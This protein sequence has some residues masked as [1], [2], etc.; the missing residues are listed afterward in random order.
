MSE[1]TNPETVETELV[2]VEEAQAEFQEEVNMDELEKEFNSFVSDMDKATNALSSEINMDELDDISTSVSEAREYLAG[3]A[4]G[5]KRTAKEKAYNTLTSLPL[6]GGWAKSQ[7]QEAQRDALENSSVKDVLDGIFS[8]FEAKK[9]RLLDLTDMIEQMRKNLVS[10]EAKLGGYITKLDIIIQ[11]PN[12][13]GRDKRRAVE[14]SVMAQAQDKITKEM[15]YNNIDIITDLMDVLY[16]K[17]IKALP[18]LKNTLNNSLNIVGTIN[19]IKDAVDM[20]NTL[21]GLTNEINQKSTATVQELIVDVTKSL[22]EGTDIEFYKD[23]AKRN[24]QFNQ[25]LLEARK[26]HIKKTVDDYKTL[27]QISVDASHQLET[28]RSEEAK[29]LASSL[30]QDIKP[31]NTTTVKG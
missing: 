30:G 29:M 25:T 5:E 13:Q 18:V 6:I 1:V 8:S 12:V 21:E 20:M 22:S 16:D 27:S 2:I 15:I 11:N 26:S 4:N 23:S 10:Q 24:E 14:M 19:S 28:R 9:V 31:A 7:V 17:I 3:F